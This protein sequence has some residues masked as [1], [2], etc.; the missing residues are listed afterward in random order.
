[1]STKRSRSA[2]PNGC[3]P[4]L[5]KEAASAPSGAVDPVTRGFDGSSGAGDDARSPIPAA[6]SGLIST[7]LIAAPSAS[8]S[9]AT[10][11]WFHV[12]DSFSGSAALLCT[13]SCSD[14]RPSPAD[15]VAPPSGLTSTGAL[16]LAS[17]YHQKT[18][19]LA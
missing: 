12:S 8:R 7:R 11:P 1:M 9:A 19:R 2:A 18:P 14:G 6:C 5:R 17:E 10:A 4:S 15:Q 3:S 13:C 16:P